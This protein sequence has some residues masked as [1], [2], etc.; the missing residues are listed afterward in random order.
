MITSGDVEK[1]SVPQMI[2]V[3]LFS[4]LFFQQPLCTEIL[5]ELRFAVSCCG[6]S[7]KP[8]TKKRQ[9]TPDYYMDG[10]GT[11]LMPLNTNYAP[12]PIGFKEEFIH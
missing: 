8:A 2:Y 5:E 7:T 11:T 3:Y 4:L 6:K 1:L 10:N 9:D 12:R